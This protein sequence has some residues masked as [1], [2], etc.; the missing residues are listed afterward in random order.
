MTFPFTRLEI[1]IFP[2]IAAFMEYK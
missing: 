2:E 1:I